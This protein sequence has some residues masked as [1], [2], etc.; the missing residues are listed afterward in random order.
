MIRATIKSELFRIVFAAVMVFAAA[1]LYLYSA[2][3]DYK[4]Y[5]ADEKS[6]LALHSK[7]AD[8][9]DSLT[10]DTQKATDTYFSI[11]NLEDYYDENNRPADDLLASLAGEHSFGKAE[12]LWRTQQYNSAGFATKTKLRDYDFFRYMSDAYLPTLDYERFV[13][14]SIARNEAL[15]QKSHSSAEDKIISEC[16]IAFLSS[17]PQELPYTASVCGVNIFAPMFSK[18]GIF[19]FF[20]VLIS[21]GMFT[22]YK[23]S[24]YMEYIKTTKCGAKK[25]CMGQYAAFALI[26]TV[27]Y[28]LYC[29]MYFLLTLLYTPD[30]SVF[31]LPMQI[32]TEVRYSVL[33]LNVGQYLMAL[34]CVR[35]LYFLVMLA[36]C[37]LISMLSPL[38]YVSM[39]VCAAVGAVPLALQ[40]FGIEGKAASL[41]C[42]D[43]I[44]FIDGGDISAC[45][46]TAV[47]DI[48]LVGAAYL[49]IF[50][51]ICA[52]CLIAGFL[53][54]GG[55]KRMVK[56]HA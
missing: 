39:A 51:A 54:F 9:I 26:F 17:M 5:S 23:Q 14:D 21:F 36:V 7:T 13:S 46:G 43:V 16:E 44:P 34:L 47:P 45:F 37:A 11:H 40:L 1:F 33:P 25:F 3:S 12:L 18:D 15:L 49:L 10:A 50:A 19:A 20:I 30:F 52:A 41:L 42:G 31:S 28:L 29:I 22:K 56:R 38:T 53:Q 32:C 4:E 35:Y 6:Y 48:I 2:N 8:F 55:G 24:R 27:G